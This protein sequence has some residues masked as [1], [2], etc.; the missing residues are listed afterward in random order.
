MP[1]VLVGA[2][3]VMFYDPRSM[4][5]LVPAWLLAAYRL[6]SSAHEHV[7]GEDVEAQEGTEDSGERGFQQQ[8]VQARQGRSPLSGWA[9]EEEEVMAP[10]ECPACASDLVRE[11]NGKTYSD[12]V[13]VEI[14]GVYDGGLFW[15]C[16][17]CSYDWHKWHDPAMRRKAEP[18]M[19]QPM[20]ST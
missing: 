11:V 13:S 7:E 14:P 12:R 17:F 5:F 1:G 3:Y 9:E 16:P 15:R 19:N 4:F 8:P 18:Y 10:D 20:S 2:A 6:G